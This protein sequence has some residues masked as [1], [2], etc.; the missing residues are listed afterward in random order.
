LDAPHVDVAGE[1]GELD[2]TQFGKGPAFPAATGRD[3]FIP[4]GRD[5]FAQRLLF[6]LHQTGKKFRDFFNAVILL[7]GCC[8]LETS[9]ISKTNGSTSVGDHSDLL[10]MRRF[11]ARRRAMQVVNMWSKSWRLNRR[12]QK[13]MKKARWRQDVYSGIIGLSRQ[14]ISSLFP[15]GSSKKQA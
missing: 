4:D 2:R 6:D 10:C 12:K 9:I 7:L 11:A 1:E 13:R 14:Q 5:F 3:R 15:S 8:H